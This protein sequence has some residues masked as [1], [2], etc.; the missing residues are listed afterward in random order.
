MAVKSDTTSS[1]GGRELQGQALVDHLAQQIQARIMSGQLARGT[2][3][4]QE[5]LAD[6]FGVSRT[7]VREALR[8]LQAS[9]MLEVEPRRGAVVHGPS[10]RD[11][12]EAYLVRAELEGVAAE[13]ATE[14]INDEQLD[15]LRAAVDRFQA[16]AND[17]A[18]ADRSAAPVADAD[19][20]WAAANETFH[21]VILDAA[22]NRR[23]RAT[24]EH[25]Y[26]TGALPRD[27][28]WPRSARAPGCSTRT[29]DSTRRSSL[30]SRRTAHRRHGSS[31]ANTS[32]GRA[33]SSR[34]LHE[35]NEDVAA[36]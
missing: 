2:R 14:L 25:L 22:G 8:Q 23:L 12:R 13:L 32:A 17:L 10:A 27:L 29:P 34:V 4:R 20:A 16:M 35:R 15:L 26:L 24:V 9:G 18:S 7:P 31:C 30:P 1:S 3:L 5:A 33:S 19:V 36:A 11:I 21:N 6:E 28:A